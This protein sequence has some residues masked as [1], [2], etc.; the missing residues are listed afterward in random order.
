MTGNK[1]R[2][3]IA[4]AAVA[5]LPGVGP[6]PSAAQD[7]P[8]TP[9]GQPE[10]VHLGMEDAV[11]RALDMNPGLEAMSEK[12]RSADRAAAASFRQH[13]GEVEAVAWASRYQDAQILRPIS[14]NLLE[15]GIS[16]L[17]FAR[18]Q[19]HYGLTF[20]VPLFVG[21]RL[22]A[23]SNMARLKADEAGVLLEG[24][25]WQ[26]SANVTSVYS[27]AQALAAVA[28]AYRENV[29]SLEETEARLRLMVAEG[30]RPEV[31][32]L[33]AS[34]T[35][36]EARAEL[37]DAQADLTYVTALLAALLGY[38]ADQTFELDPLP[39]RFP[40]LAADTADLTGLVEGGSAV[41]AAE[42]RV[43]QA[44]RGKQVARSD[45][46]PTVSVRGNLLEHTAS[47]VSGPERT[48]ELTLAASIPVF[49]GGRSMAAY[50]S[51]A[52]AQ[53]AADLA[54]QQTRL[55]QQAEVRGA[56]ARFN[57][58]TT[59]LDAARRRVDAAAEAARIES[60]RYENGAGTIEDLL[61]ARTRASAAEAALAKAKG[62]VLSAA[63]RINALVERE[64]VQ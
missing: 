11:A 30:K 17:P 4:I 29:A 47:S 63:A 27:S 51:A 28:M 5:I 8:V 10:A 6:E 24:T 48:W 33:K 44:E 31:D 62:D 49:T 45:F 14:Q 52:A 53:R 46:L 9:A 7:L 60:L 1:L 22:L 34:E 50:Q 57:A 37:A 41:A 26:V 54:L 16:G 36:E 19:L 23:G 55:Q 25:R 12:A 20:Q 2:I 42:L 18:D 39:D 43:R 3:G 40:A 38:P 35:L 58:A 13:F 64:I 15:E 59:G 21:G 32:L 56:L 61:R